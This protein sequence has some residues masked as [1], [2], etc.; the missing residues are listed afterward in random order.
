[1][2][3]RLFLLTVLMYAVMFFAEPVV[4][5]TINAYYSASQWEEANTARAVEFGEVVAELSE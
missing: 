4:A 2:L 5:T 1:M 3:T